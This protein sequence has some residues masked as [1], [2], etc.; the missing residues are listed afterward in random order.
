MTDEV[1]DMSEYAG[2]N[3]L[4]TKPGHYDFKNV[5]VQ[6]IHVVA[7]AVHISNVALTGQLAYGG[8]APWLNVPRSWPKFWKKGQY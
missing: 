4:I 3:V 6:N 1:I 7:Q 8:R 5:E 2:M